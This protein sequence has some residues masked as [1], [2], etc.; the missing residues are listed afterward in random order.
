MI[1]PFMDIYTLLEVINIAL[2]FMLTLS[3]IYLFLFAV[4]S[5]FYRNVVHK[6]DGPTNRFLILFPAYKEDT[7]IL[8]AVNSFLEQDYDKEKYQVIVIADAMEEHTNNQLGKLP[9]RLLKANYTN[10][11]KAK[12]L[13]MAIAST[14]EEMYDMVIIMDADNITEV[15]FLS[16]VNDAY[17]AG[18]HFIQTHRKA[19]NMNTDI[20]VLD[21]VSEEINNSIFRKGHTVL[22]LSSAF[23]GSGMGLSYSW[24]RDHVNC[25]HTAGEDKELEILLLKE[26]IHIS[27][28]QEITV[29]D[30]KVQKK[31]G[32]EKQR[33]RWLSAQFTSFKKLYPYFCKGVATGNIDLCNKVIQW[34]MLPRI[35]LLLSVLLFTLLNIVLNTAIE[36]AWWVLSIGLF[37]SIII[38]IPTAML[39]KKTFKTIIHLPL[40][41]LMMA[42]NL[43]KLNR[44]GT[45]FIHTSHGCDKEKEKRK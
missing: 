39:T 13:Q 29:Y 2:L 9:I 15:D 41:S 28:L 6:K 3:V 33:L 43:L 19:K 17:N 42:R 40:L 8:E 44:V 38:A 25:L 20:A 34:M 31:E 21:A 11:S 32:L 27:Y 4:A 22:G 30:E 7:V 5:K 24:F 36:G 45:K 23:I 16:R 1:K 26:R 35:I 10:S 12:A 18:E 14:K 37:L